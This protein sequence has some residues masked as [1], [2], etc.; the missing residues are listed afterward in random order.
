MREMGSAGVSPANLKFLRQSAAAAVGELSSE[1][2]RAGL[3]TGVRDLLFGP[4]PPSAGALL[5]APATGI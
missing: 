2:G 1:P 5:A 3:R 4:V